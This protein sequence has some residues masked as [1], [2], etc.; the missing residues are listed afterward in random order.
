MYLIVWFAN[1]RYT[2]RDIGKYNVDITW[3]IEDIQIDGTH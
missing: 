3:I 2:V 1:K